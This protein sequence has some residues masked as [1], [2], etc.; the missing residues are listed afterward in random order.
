MKKYCLVLTL[1][2][3][4]TH[5]DVCS[6][7]RDSLLGVYDHST[8]YRFGNAFMKGNQRLTY[9]DLA[10]E[11]TSPRTFEMYQKSK[12]RIRISRVLNFSSIAV[13][14]VS[15]FTHTNVKGSIEFAV[16]TG[17]LGLGALYFQTE[18]GKYIDRAIWEKNR[19]ILL[20]QKV[21]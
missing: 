9:N 5:S 6:Q 16:A 12:R 13:I 7:T 2:F 1:V 4:F 8:I 15:V 20:G 10:F 17:T 3:V 19:D 14:I 11:F 18:S 21:E